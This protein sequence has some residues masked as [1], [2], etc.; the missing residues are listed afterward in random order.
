MVNG[1]KVLE[2]VIWIEIL[3]LSCCASNDVAMNKVAGLWGD[4]CF[5]EGDIQAPLAVKRVCIKTR[6]P[7]LIHEKISVIIQGISYELVVRELS[8]WEPNIVC[9]EEALDCELLNC[10]GNSDNE[11]NGYEDNEGECTS[12]SINQT[13]F[14]AFTNEVPNEKENCLNITE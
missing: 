2:R 13:K 3:G 11:E 10:S 1:F 9:N 14:D 12:S 4:M 5:L 8:N 6:K 7:S